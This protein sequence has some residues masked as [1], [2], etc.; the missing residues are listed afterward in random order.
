LNIQRSN[1]SDNKR[2]YFVGRF[3]KNKRIAELI[4]WLDSPD[5]NI[6]EF[7]IIGDGSEKEKLGKIANYLKYVK[8]IFTGWLDK[9]EQ[10]KL[11]SNNDIF[12]SNSA[13]EGEPLV[14]REANERGSIVI[15][16]NILGHRG[17][18]YKSNRFNNQ[19]ELLKLISLANEGKLRRFRNRSIEEI[20]R[21]RE[22][23][24]KK[25]FI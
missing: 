24:V 20:N 4:E 2:L 12:I 6:T 18:T 19:S 3:D 8:I 23:A 25:V 1:Q 22:D 13:F 9:I 16:R 17:C 14:I 15:A 7:I 5:N 11:L 10:E 21:K